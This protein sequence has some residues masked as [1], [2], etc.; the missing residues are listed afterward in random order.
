MHGIETPITDKNFFFFFIQLYVYFFIVSYNRH[1]K[2]M[3]LKIQVLPTKFISIVIAELGQAL[4][5]KK[6]SMTFDT[7]HVRQRIFSASLRFG[8]IIVIK[9]GF[10]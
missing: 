6:T 1:I 4:A 5:C 2:N 8:K 3:I 9:I 7:I 10:S